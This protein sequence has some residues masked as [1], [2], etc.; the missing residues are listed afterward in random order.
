[1]NGILI[2]AL[3]SSPVYEQSLPISL[4][5]DNDVILLLAVSLRPATIKR[6]KAAVRR[7]CV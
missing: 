5:D 1:V 6:K 3:L 7:L 2:K 4:R